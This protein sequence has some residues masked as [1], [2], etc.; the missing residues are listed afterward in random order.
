LADADITLAVAK[1]VEELR[2]AGGQLSEEGLIRVAG[3]IAS[4]FK[5]RKQEVAILRVSP[6]GQTLSFL[7]PTKLAKIGLI[8]LSTTHSLATK[9]IRERR[10]EIVNNF[11]AYKHP[12]VFEAV[13][14][15][16]HEKA[17][18]IQKIISAP[19]LVNDKVVGVIQVG[20]KGRPGDPI[21]PDFTPNDVA[22]LASVGAIL[23]KFLTTFSPAPTSPA[24]TAE[25]P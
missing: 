2:K 7:F 17:A 8:P 20:R 6:D 16:E 12:T 1:I 24:Q 19:M 10:G 21:G 18:P 9:T 11:P 4:G 22:D 13:D 25:T 23:G 3:Q 15:S 14:L 5:V